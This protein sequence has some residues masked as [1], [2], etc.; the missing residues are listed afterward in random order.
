[1]LALHSGIMKKPSSL[2]PFSALVTAALILS[3]CGKQEAVG[4]V[5]SSEELAQRADAASQAIRDEAAAA[6]AGEGTGEAVAIDSAELVSYTNALRGF[7]IM[8][9]K[10]WKQ[11]DGGS[12]DDGAAFENADLDM[13]LM[14]GWTEN[15]DDA[16]LLAA[17]GKLETAENIAGE[18]VND[19]EYRASGNAT[20]NQAKSERILRKPDGTM[21]RA[22]VTYPA[23][24]AETLGN[25]ATQILDSLS[26][27]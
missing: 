26:L 15:R 6:E 13:K 2:L 10:N 17:V 9:P 12:D 19:D 20:E 11:V 18:Y 3:S 16:G 21:V 25:L 7:S 5:P 23:E 14:A 1:M 8:V 24:N 22:V 27:Q 4:D